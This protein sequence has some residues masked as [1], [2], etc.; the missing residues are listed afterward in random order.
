M[1]E[2]GHIYVLVNPSIEGLVKIGKTTRDP[3]SRARELSQATGVATPFYVGYS[4]EVADCHSAEEYVHAVL[5][6]NGFK[7]SPNREFFQM[8]LRKAIE[9]LL[10]AEKE[11]A[12]IAAP[13][14]DEA[15]KRAFP[16]SDRVTDD[17]EQLGEEPPRHPG[18]ALMAKAYAVYYGVGDEL[19]DKQEALRLI[20]QAKA[21][22]FP[23]AYTSLAWHFI[24]EAEHAR[25]R[26]L[27]D[28]GAHQL[29]DKAFDILKEGVEK[30]HGRCYVMM[31]DM[32]ADGLR[33][34]A[35]RSDP[36]NANKCWRK[37]FRSQTFVN[38]NDQ[39]YIT[40]GIGEAGTEH[41]L[42]DEC[43]ARDRGCLAFRYFCFCFHRKIPP[44][45]EVLRIVL[46][47]REAILCEVREVLQRSLERVN[48]CDIEDEER[49]SLTQDIEDYPRIFDLVGWTL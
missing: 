5:E 2:P 32:Y 15:D 33:N 34:Q 26:V 36:E 48:K 38:N 47:L 14:E 37:Y 28:P 35:W 4:I 49:E 8:P 39:R 21:L 42:S 18:N 29:C 20:C 31:A 43:G 19:E 46:P 10:L 45:Q 9:V 27:D 1:K 44:D 41:E 23:A 7:R 17:A 24:Q 6:H 40:W 13:S 25:G 22:N 30:G 3:E 16:L 11:I 12:S